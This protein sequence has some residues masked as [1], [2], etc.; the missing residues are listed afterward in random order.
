M[1]Q[2]HLDEYCWTKVQWLPASQAGGQSV[3]RL[4][5]QDCPFQERIEGKKQRS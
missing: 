5:R 4:L 1:E 2:C 3:S